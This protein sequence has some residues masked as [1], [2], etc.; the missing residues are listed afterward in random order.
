MRYR[1]HQVE[2]HALAGHRQSILPSSGT[3]APEI[4]ALAEVLRD[5]AAHVLRRLADDTRESAPRRGGTS[6]RY[7]V[8][9]WSLSSIEHARCRDD[10]ASVGP[11]HHMMQRHAGLALAIDDHPVHR[12]APA[13]FGATTIHEG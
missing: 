4:A 9:A 10:V 2:N 1:A 8:G 12:S 7:R 6:L 11:R 13:I 5:A 3:P